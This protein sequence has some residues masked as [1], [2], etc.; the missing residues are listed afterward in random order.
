MNEPIFN[1]NQPYTIVIRQQW[2]PP[3]AA[4]CMVF[5]FKKAIIT[6]LLKKLGLLLIN[7]NYKSVSNVEFLSKRIERTVATQLVNHLSENNLM[8]IFQSAYQQSYSTDTALL[9]VQ[10]YILMEI[11]NGNVVLLVLLD[12]SAAF[13]TIYHE[14]LLNR[15]STRWGISV[16]VLKDSALI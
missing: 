7:K 6:P 10:N 3:G 16:I 9:C 5:N 1:L 13:D 2:L 15:L 11:D 14:I 8:N 12:L 4:N